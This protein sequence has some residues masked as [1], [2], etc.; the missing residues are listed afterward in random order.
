MSVL[1]DFEDFRRGAD[2]INC[3]MTDGEL[4]RAFPATVTILAEYFGIDLDKFEDEKRQM[5]DV[6]RRANESQG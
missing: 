2:P 3:E 1:D 6:I 5:L 4:Y